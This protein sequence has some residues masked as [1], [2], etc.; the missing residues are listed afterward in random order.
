MR[1]NPTQLLASIAVVLVGTCGFTDLAAAESSSTDWQFTGLIYGYLPALSGSATF[2]TGKPINITIDQQ[3]IL[4]NLNFAFMGSFEVRKGPWGG[5][6]DVVYANVGDSKSNTRDF[7]LGGVAI[8]GSVTANLRLDAR[9]T[10]W[11]LAGFYRVVDRPEVTLDVLLGARALYLRQQLDWQFSGDV[12]PLV[13]PGRNGSGNS[14]STTWDGI[15]G[16]KGRWMFGDRR[17]WFVPYYFDIGTGGSQLTYQ[18]LAGVGYGFS[19]GDIIAVWRYID[20]RFSSH[21]AS[22]SMNGP[23][24]GVAFHW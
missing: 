14:N 3:D 20:Y 6:T 2:P 10:L 16:V 11:T 19:W 1:R 21:D 17:A 18:A 8:P 15:V 5:F 4:S 24:I 23:A 13:G 7:S 12:G 9:T 22:L